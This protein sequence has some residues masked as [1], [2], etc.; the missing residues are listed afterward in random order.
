MVASLDPPFRVTSEGNKTRFVYTGG[1]SN[2][3]VVT[4]LYRECNGEPLEGPNGCA[5]SPERKT[6]YYEETH[7]GR[8]WACELSGSGEVARRRA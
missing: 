6:L 1:A 2:D 8:V 5:L 3:A 4:V 7:T